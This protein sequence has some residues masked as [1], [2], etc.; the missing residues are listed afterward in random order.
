MSQLPQ[1]SS[2]KEQMGNILEEARMVLP[3]VQA[4]FGFQTVAVFNQRFD[5][6]ANA[7]KTAHVVALLSVVVAIGLVMMPAAW[8]RIVEPHQVSAT[9]V[10]LASKM[11][12]CALFPLAVGVALDIY[13]VLLV[14]SD[15][16]PLSISLAVLTLLLLLGL[17]FLIPSSWRNRKKR[18]FRRS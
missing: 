17:W 7:A 14:A 12:C 3:G 9:T 8:H 18:R 4:L 6:L 13:V 11:I 10:S 1:P 5:E 15:S 2:L 16:A